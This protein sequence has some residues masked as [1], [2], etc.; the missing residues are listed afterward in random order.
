MKRFVSN[1]VREIKELTPECEWKYCSTS[2]NPA[3]LLTRGISSEQ[4][5]SSE[6]WMNGPTFLVKRELEPKME[7]RHDTALS[8]LTEE[9]DTEEAR[10][11]NDT[12]QHIQ[13]KIH[14]VMDL[15]NYGSYG[16][17]LNVT[18]YVLRF[19]ENCRSKR[20]LRNTGPLKTEEIRNSMT[21]WIR[22]CQESA[23]M[24]EIRTLENNS[25]RLPRISQLRLYLDKDKL[26]RC[27]GRI[28]N[29]PLSEAAKFPYLLPANHRFSELIVMNSHDKVL[30]SGVNTTVSFIRQN[31]WIPAIRQFVRKILR[32]CIICRKV[33][34][35]PYPS[36]EM[37]PLQKMRL[38]DSP[39]FTATG[40]DFTGALNIKHKDKS[41]SKAYIC[42]FTCAST[43]AIHLEVVTNLTESSFLQAFRRFVSRRSVPKVIM[44]DN[45][46]TFI[47]AS[48][49]LKRIFQSDKVQREF[50][51][52]GIEWRFIPKRAPWFGGFW[53][54]MIGL[55]KNCLKKVLGSSLV[56]LETLQTVTTEAENVLNDRPLTYIS[57]DIDDD[58]PLT[59]AHLL[60]GRRITSVPY[61]QN[62]DFDLNECYNIH[63]IDV[64]DRAKRQSLLLQH[65]QARWRNEYLTALREYHS[66]SGKNY[67]DVK[68]GDIVQIEGDGTRIGWKTAIIE[69]V[70]RGNDGIPRSAVLRT[71]RGRTTRPLLKLYPLELCCEETDAS[72]DDTTPCRPVGSASLRAKEKI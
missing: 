34:G 46:T 28:H 44:S 38:Q 53:E 3:D 1:R 11:I 63:T 48:E 32:K 9:L 23:F 65:F 45:A 62:M 6:L 19:I 27:E 26:L 22:N 2:V 39:P 43:R 59:P 50:R 29:A 14:V 16:K 21:L 52:R 56:D 5:K 68:K 41:V 70:V 25:K 72:E 12:H 7:I 42:L 20:E 66:K 69:E 47:A 71:A 60:Y 24:P 61:L 13:N 40:I 10:I 51:N 57:M 33:T 4:L 15:N 64:S 8:L 31:F 35:R 58:E 36:T 67:I 55:T 54:R 18:A 17:L 30:H 37:A 49:H